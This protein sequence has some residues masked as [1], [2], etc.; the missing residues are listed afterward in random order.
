[1]FGWWFRRSSPRR[2]QACRLVILVLVRKARDVKTAVLGTLAVLIEVRAAL[3]CAVCLVCLGLLFLVWNLGRRLHL[4]CCLLAALINPQAYQSNSS[5]LCWNASIC[6][7]STTQ[8]H[9]T[10]AAQPNHLN[11]PH[12]S[13]VLAPV[14][15]SP[16]HIVKP[17]PLSITFLLQP[18]SH[19]V[20]SPAMMA[21]LSQAFALWPHVV[22]LRL[23]L[24]GFHCR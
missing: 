6:F 21:L 5:A 9:F 22:H 10:S 7:S 1:M 8:R 24:V 3:I 17:T 23:G 2:S 12:F 19:G 16:H 20:I 18:M 13:Q 4:S 14:S 11:N 15:E